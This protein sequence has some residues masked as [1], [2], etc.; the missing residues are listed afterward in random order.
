MIKLVCYYLIN[1]FILSLFSDFSLFYQ[2]INKNVTYERIE[3][4]VSHIKLLCIDD[5]HTVGYVVVL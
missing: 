1:P 5:P 3:T 4:Q 2:H